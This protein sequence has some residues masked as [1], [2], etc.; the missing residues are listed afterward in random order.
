[1]YTTL[2]RLENKGL[3][4]SFMGKPR[5]VRSG[6]ARRYYRLEPEGVEALRASREALERMWSGL[7]PLAGTS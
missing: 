2:D 3:L 7:E 1:V 4:S 6:R 5:A